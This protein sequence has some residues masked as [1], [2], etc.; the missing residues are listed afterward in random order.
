MTSHD[1]IIAITLPSIFSHAGDMT[2][3]T[4][5][6]QCLEVTVAVPSGLFW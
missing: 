5:Q 2:A 4:Q 1:E 6:L 3:R